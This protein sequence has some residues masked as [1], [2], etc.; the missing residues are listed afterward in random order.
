MMSRW[1]QWRINRL[2]VKLRKEE[3]YAKRLNDCGFTAGP[4]YADIA[5]YKEKLRQLGYQE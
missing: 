5:K 2:L 3:A 4:A 1:R